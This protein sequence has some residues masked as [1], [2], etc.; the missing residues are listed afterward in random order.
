MVATDV[1]EIIS[2]AVTVGRFAHV[3]MYSQI[4]RLES[5][6]YGLHHHSLNEG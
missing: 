2:L 6:Q 1:F 3:Y 4:M 5:Y